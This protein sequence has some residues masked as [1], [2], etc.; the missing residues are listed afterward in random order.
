M[1]T[2]S[3]R[4]AMADPGTDPQ[5][6]TSPRRGPAIAFAAV[7]GLVIGVVVVLLLTGND[8]DGDTASDSDSACESVEEPEPKQVDIPPPDAKRP[9]AGAVAFTTTCG[10]FTV[11]LDGERA[12]KTAASFEY[13]AEEGVFDGTGFHRVAP[14]FV[15]QAGDPGGDGTGGPGY[16]ITERP[17][18]DLSYTRGLVAMAKSGAEPPGASGSQFFVVTAEA[19]AGLPPDYAVV[20]EVTDGMDTV[21]AIDALGEGPGYDGPP[22]QPVVIESAEVE[23]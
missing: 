20:G 3:A 21:M 7:V 13:L 19:D 22:S 17:P 23:G 5:Q 8:D 12:P 4:P 6:S 2:S 1:P 9:S 11:S 14:G 18:N 15:V 16:S 10:S